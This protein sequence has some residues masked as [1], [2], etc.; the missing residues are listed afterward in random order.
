VGLLAKNFNGAPAPETGENTGTMGCPAITVTR[1]SYSPGS[2]S[3]GAFVSHGS[4]KTPGAGHVNGFVANVFLANMFS[5]QQFTGFV[6]L[7]TFRL[8]LSGPVPNYLSIR[9]FCK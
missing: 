3:P 7:V 2:K 6:G 4:Y 1:T 5:C 9:V 8:S